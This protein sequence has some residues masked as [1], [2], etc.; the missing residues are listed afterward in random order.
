MMAPSARRPK[1]SGIT[2]TT[3]VSDALAEAFVIEGARPLS[4][5]IRAASTNGAP[6]ARRPSV[7]LMNV[8]SIAGP[9]GHA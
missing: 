6:S 8:M 2:L 4:G 3:I 5:S 7:G 1:T 9:S